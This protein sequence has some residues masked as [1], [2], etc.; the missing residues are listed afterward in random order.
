MC[1]LNCNPHADDG[2]GSIARTKQI[3]VTDTA[4]KVENVLEVVES[5]KVPPVQPVVKRFDLQHVDVSAVMGVAAPHIGVPVGQMESVDIS[6]SSD[7]GGK[8]LFVTGTP[9]KVAKLEALIKVLDLETPVAADV[10]DMTLR[11]HAITG[12]NLQSVY[13][14][15]QTVLA[16]KP[17]RL[18]MQPTTKSIVALADSESHKVIE[19]TIQ[20]MQAPMIEFAVVDLGTLDPTSP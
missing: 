14:V 4:G 6:V 3:I 11:S 13:D 16:G 8:I 12:D 20:E 19:M 15:L 1:L 2:S 18:S 7:V 10:T 9:E 17:L 5:L